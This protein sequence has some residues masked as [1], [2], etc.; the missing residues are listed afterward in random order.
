VKRTFDNEVPEWAS[1]AHRKIHLEVLD[2]MIDGTPVGNIELWE[3]YW[4][5]WQHTGIPPSMKGYV[6]GRARS[7]WQSSVLVPKGGEPNGPNASAYPGGGETKTL[8]RQA[9]SGLKPYSRSF[10][11]NNTPYIV[12]LNDGLRGKQHTFQAPLMWM[13]AALDRVAAQFR[14]GAG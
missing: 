12:V 9:L 3:I 6:G 8:N 1:K 5:L 13:E 10:I 2:E 4:E 11:T 7:N 14:T